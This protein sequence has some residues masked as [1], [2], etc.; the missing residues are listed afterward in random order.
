MSSPVRPLFLLFG[1]KEWIQQ[2]H[3]FS[4]PGRRRFFL[5]GREF[6]L[7]LFGAVVQEHNHDLLPLGDDRLTRGC[8]ILFADLVLR[9]IDGDPPGIGR[10]VL[11]GLH[12]LI[13][14]VFLLGFADAAEAVDP[15]VGRVVFILPDGPAVIAFDRVDLA[16]VRIDGAD[17][18]DV[19][20]A[21]VSAVFK[22]DQISGDGCIAVLPFFVLLIADKEAEF[23]QGRDPVRAVLVQRNVVLRNPRTNTHT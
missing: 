10:R 17:D 21:F 11:N 4:I 7:L 8:G 5:L 15:P 20:G 19:V 12:E 18:A 16:G 1:L 14:L 2:L 22:E 9:C 3:A 23:V 6:F 13:L